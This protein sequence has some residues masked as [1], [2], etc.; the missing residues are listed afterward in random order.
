[1]SVSDIVQHGSPRILYTCDESK[2]IKLTIN[3]MKRD[4]VH[5]ISIPIFAM[6]L[7]RVF[8]RLNLRVHIKILD[9]HAT[10]TENSTV[11]TQD[12]VD[13]VEGTA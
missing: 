5:R 13:S 11:R 6:A 3:R 1:M 8:P 9:G 2:S 4:G 10:L 7:E 12:T